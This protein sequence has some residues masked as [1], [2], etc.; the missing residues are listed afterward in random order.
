MIGPVGVAM[1]AVLVGSLGVLLLGLGMVAG[2]LIGALVLELIV[3]TGSEGVQLSSVVGI[4]ITLLAVALTSLDGRAK[5]AAP[6]TRGAVPGAADRPRDARDAPG[7]AA[8][9]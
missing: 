7:S 2:Q 4:L 3:P 5:R 1:T 9:G 6:A 8:A